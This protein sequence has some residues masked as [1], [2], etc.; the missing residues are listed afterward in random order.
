L[1]I[2]S[3]IGSHFATV[4]AVDLDE[5]MKCR[6]YFQQK[7]RKTRRKKL[8]FFMAKTLIRTVFA[9]VLG[10]NMDVGLLLD[11][12]TILYNRLLVDDRKE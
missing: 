2:I 3:E 11:T 12:T 10:V 5:L 9:L 8:F 1:V 7:Q 6:K 4:K